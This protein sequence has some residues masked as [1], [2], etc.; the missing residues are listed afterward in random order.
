MTRFGACVFTVLAQVFLLTAPRAAHAAESY[1]NCTGFITSL[2]VLI[3][4]QGVW[5]LKQDLSTAITAGNAITINTYNVTL[6]CNGFKIGGLAA[7]VSTAAI[8]IYELSQLNATV[9]HC[10]IRGFYFGLDFEGGGGG[11]TV[12]DNRFDS[13]T[14]VGLKVSGDGSVVQRNRVLDTGGSTLVTMDAFAIKTVDNVD[15]LDNT[16]SGIAATSG[17][18]G[19]AYGISTFN[20]STGSISDNRVNGLLK[21][22]TGAAYGIFNDVSGRVI[23]TGNH[24]VGDSSTGSAGLR[25][26]SG[27]ETSSGNVISGFATGSTCPDD[28]GNVVK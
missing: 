4:T 10:R 28:G 25:C 13:N 17:G 26:D 23:M 22:G 8:G 2:P 6:D 3:N 24:L 19:S 16:V 21:D 12:E 9:R 14:Y 7:G 20:N 27:N 5:C 18:N 11:H 1:D 15:V